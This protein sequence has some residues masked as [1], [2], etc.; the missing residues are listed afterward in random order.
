MR[1]DGSTDINV[2][3]YGSAWAAK[4]TLVNGTAHP[5]LLTTSHAAHATPA[6]QS[7]SSL[8]A[9]SKFLFLSLA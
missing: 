9:T 4:R 8:L 6:A 1:S 3:R 7:I 5:M 2:S